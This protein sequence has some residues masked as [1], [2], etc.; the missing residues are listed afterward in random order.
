[1][2]NTTATAHR[3]DALVQGSEA[4]AVRTSH[5]PQ[6]PDSIAKALQNRSAR[7][8]L[9]DRVAMRIGLWL[10]LWGTRPTRAID[11]DDQTI[12]R[13]DSRALRLERALA[14][15][16]AALDRARASAG[17]IHFSGPVGR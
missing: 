9:P 2:S 16:H 4:Q 10:V 13:R 14:E 12:S 1:M 11:A 5:P 3:H 6:P 8:S 17:L 7:T 15:Q